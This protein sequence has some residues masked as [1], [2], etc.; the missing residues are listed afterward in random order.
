MQ[1]I[2]VLNPKGGSGKTTIAINLASY[3]ASRRQ[4][5]VLMDFDPQG[6]SLRW[7][8]KRRPAQPPIL[9]IAAFEKDS[10]TTRAFQLRVPDAAT[11]VV[12]DTPAALDPREL[13]DMTRDADKILVPVLPSDI[14]I[15]ACSRCIRDLL[16]VAKIR[17]DEN[18]IGVIANRI[19]RNTVTYQSLIRFL[20][21]L[22]IPIVATIRDSQNYVRGAELGIGVHEMKSYVAQEDVA[23]WVPLVEWLA[24]QAGAEQAPPGASSEGADRAE[25]AAPQLGGDEPASAGERAGA[26]S[27]AAAG[28]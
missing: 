3:L 18:R 28:G 7:V 20:H 19:R 15:H 23:Q 4:T 9:V 22:G 12:V 11:H 2:V 26:V 21:T 10:R 24:G 27:Q 8:R 25:G 1:R 13:A 14:D 16:L 17:R 5:P 6:S